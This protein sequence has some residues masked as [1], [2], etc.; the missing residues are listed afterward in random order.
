MGELPDPR[1]PPGQ[2]LFHREFGRGVEIEGTR[3]AVIRV[4]QNGGE[5]LQMRLQPGAHL[6]GRGIDLDKAGLGKEIAHRLQH[7]AAHRELGAAFGEAVRPPPWLGHSAIPV[8]RIP[9]S[10]LFLNW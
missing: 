3:G 6:Q 2:Q 9:L 7:P 8:R 5:G 10:P 4:V 1:Q